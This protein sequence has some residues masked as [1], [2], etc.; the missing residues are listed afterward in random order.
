MLATAG[1]FNEK[2]AAY[3]EQ[4][5]M[6]GRFELTD[7]DLARIRARRADLFAQWEQLAEGDTMELAFDRLPVRRGRAFLAGC[8]ESLRDSLRS[9]L[10]HAAWAAAW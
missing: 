5:E 2:A 7:A 6:P 1:E 8:N 3:Y 4:H 10:R 9:G